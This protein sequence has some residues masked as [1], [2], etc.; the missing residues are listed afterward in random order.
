MGE[1]NLRKDLY[2]IS[3]FYDS[4]FSATDTDLCFSNLR[5]FST[6]KYLKPLYEKLEAIDGRTYPLHN[7]KKLSNQLAESIGCNSDKIKIIKSCNVKFLQHNEI[8]QKT[9]QY[10]DDKN[11]QI[12]LSDNHESHKHKNCINNF[13]E[14]ESS[15]INKIKFEPSKISI[16]LSNINENWLY[17]AYSWHKDL[18]VKIDGKFEKPRLANI[19]FMAIN[20]HNNAKK[21]EITKKN[22]NLFYKWYLLIFN[23]LLSILLIFI[24]F[25]NKLKKYFT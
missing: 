16:E 19:G 15:K 2:Q 12:Y 3:A 25:I 9:F 24:F 17:L 1:L 20:L 8:L 13:N 22:D 4:T 11:F 23:F 14:N 21:I 10:S 7:N 18:V 6:S 5:R